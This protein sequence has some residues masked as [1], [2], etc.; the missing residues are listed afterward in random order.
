VNLRTAPR[1]ALVSAAILVLPVSGAPQSPGASPL[2]SV[3]LLPPVQLKGEEGWSLAER[4]HHHHVEAV[5]VALI[6]DYRLV[7]EAAVGLADREEGKEATAETLFQ[8][9]SISKP[10]AAAALL[11]EAEKGTFRL[12]ADV[13]AFLKSWKLPDNELTA[14]EKVTLERILSHG[15]GLTVHGFPGYAAGEAVPTVPQVLD[16]APPANTAPVRVDLVPGSKWRY[17]GGG[18]TIA[19]LAMSDTLGQAFPDLMRTLVLGPAGM[20]L[21]SYEQPLPASRLLQAAAG[22]RGD[23]SPVPGKRHVYPEMA[24]AGLWTTAGDL[25]RFAIAIQ[26]SLRGEPGSLLSPPSAERMVT[27]FIAEYGLGFAGEKHGRERYFS[28]GGADEGFQAYLVAHR[29]GWGA[30]VMTNSDNGVAL[31]FE[32]LR[33]LARQESWKGYLPEPLVPVVLS[34]DELRALA[35]RYRVSGDEA[36]TVESRGGRAYGRSTGDA[37]FELFG[38]EGD[39]LAR[40]DRAIRYGVLRLEGGVRALAIE[41]DEGRSEAPRMSPGETIPFDHVAAGRLEEA[42]S[43]YRALQSS[44]PDDPGVAEPRLNRLGYQL[45]GRQELKAALVV[46]QVNT[47]L[48]PD[49]ANTWD[50]LGEVLL[51]DGQR[52]RAV[53]CYRKV[54]EA[55]PR[56]QKA[57][58]AAKSQLRAN[59]ERQ[60]RE[61]S[62]ERHPRH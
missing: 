55:L 14:R 16:G 38:V 34:A 17:S 48:Y 49:S 42:I 53:E 31:A 18:Y 30:A 2:E 13:N 43:A 44:K 51:R 12:D 36:V 50:S 33:G 35:G 3:R 57:D 26:K 39:R 21:S 9:G 8:A 41:D 40:K 46:L 15:A 28:H 47:A 10:V 5:Q 56:D 62:A 45:A 60:I 19:Q 20:S 32:I 4:M 37:E 27:P 25:A 54:L 23:G 1:L 7:W 11:R 61:L 24:A 59:A 6:R 52:T 22:Y 29:G 58:E